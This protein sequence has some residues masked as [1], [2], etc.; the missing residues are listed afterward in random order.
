MLVCFAIR[1]HIRLTLSPQMVFRPH[2]LRVNAVLRVNRHTVDSLMVF[3]NRVL[4]SMFVGL[5][6]WNRSK[7]ALNL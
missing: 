3:Q 7:F 6:I 5:G 2:V 1:S 4:G